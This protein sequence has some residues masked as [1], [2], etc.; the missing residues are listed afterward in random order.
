MLTF[1]FYGE[2]TILILRYGNK[3]ALVDSQTRTNFDGKNQ[4]VR[5]VFSPVSKDG[6]GWIIV[7]LISVPFICIKIKYLP[8]IN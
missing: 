5:F 4:I 6:W 8:L 3:S 1:F 7:I 2:E